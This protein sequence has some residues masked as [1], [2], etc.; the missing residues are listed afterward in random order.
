MS[1]NNQNFNNE[2]QITA[3]LRETPYGGVYLARNI[4]TGQL[5]VKRVLKDYINMSLMQIK[6]LTHPNIPQIYDVQYTATDTIVI[7]EYIQGKT[8]EDIISNKGRMSK[9]LVIDIM[10]NLCSALTFIHTQK[11]P[12]IHRDIKPA[13]IM[14]TAAGEV[15][16]IDFGAARQYAKGNSTDTEFIGTSTYAS[17]EQYGFGQSDARSDV[18][19]CGI[20]FKEMLTGSV[21]G[22]VSNKK[23]EPDYYE[24]YKN[25]S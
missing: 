12:I 1:A 11:P 22:V 7:E 2:W 23:N 14:L 9:K 15:K 6:G 10:I 20:I 25:G 5:A 18:Y 16:L 17:P 8:L 4:H 3:T 24:M 21:D 19:S 13:N